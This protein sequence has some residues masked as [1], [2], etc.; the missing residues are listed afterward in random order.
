MKHMFEIRT[1]CSKP[2][3]ITVSDDTPLY[4]LFD[5][6]LDNVEYHTIL[7]R[8]DVTDIF[9][10]FESECVSITKTNDTVKDMI[11]KYLVYYRHKSQVFNNGVYCIYVIDR[12]YIERIKNECDTPVY[13]E[14]IIPPSNDNKNVTDII[15]TTIGLLTGVY[16]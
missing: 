10:P 1:T 5:L 15:K 13:N 9:V 16:L 7:M 6:I 12:I 3:T 11:N 2:F 14:D 4:E 8:T